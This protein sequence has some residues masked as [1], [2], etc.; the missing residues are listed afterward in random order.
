MV[1]EPDGTVNT[2]VSALPTNTLEPKQ[3]EMRRKEA[4]EKDGRWDSERPSNRKGLRL[5]PESELEQASKW[6]QRDDQTKSKKVEK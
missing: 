3:P 4:G 5:R 2:F 6:V 1:D